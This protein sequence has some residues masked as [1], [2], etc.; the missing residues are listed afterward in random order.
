MA[1]R[2]IKIENPNKH[3]VTINLK[4]FNGRVIPIKGNGIAMLE[5]DELAYVVTSSQVFNRGTLR[6]ANKQELTVIDKSD[7]ESPN[8][9]TDEEVVAMLKN[10]KAL[11]TALLQID[12]ERVLKRV[13]EKANE[14]NKSVKMVG[15][16][17]ARIEELLM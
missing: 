6:V 13:L 4:E 17:E 3:E 7:L 14:L 8:A 10:Q 11:E 16:I 1:K 9:L 2:N 5:E 15:M 12:N